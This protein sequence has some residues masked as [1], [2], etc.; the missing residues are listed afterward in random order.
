MNTTI[1]FLVLFLAF[2]CGCGDSGVRDAGVKLSK[3][4]TA[5]SL[6]QDERLLWERYRKLQPLHYSLMTYEEKK[7][8]WSE[9]DIPVMRPTLDAESRMTDEEKRKHHLDQIL[10]AAQYL[11]PSTKAN[12]VVDMTSTPDPKVIKWFFWKGTDVKSA[13]SA[14]D[15]ALER[16]LRSALLERQRKVK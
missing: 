6:S 1:V 13:D 4:K 15:S 9:N 12:A 14:P 8:E 7:G 5:T 16:S 11:S 10:Q 3:A 2:C